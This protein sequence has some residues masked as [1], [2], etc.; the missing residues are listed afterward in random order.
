MSYF[1][2]NKEKGR[3]LIFNPASGEQWAF[4][5][6]FSENICFRVFFRLIDYFVNLSVNFCE[7]QCVPAVEAF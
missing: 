3:L 6:A 4:P 7:F 1:P 2:K 5:Y